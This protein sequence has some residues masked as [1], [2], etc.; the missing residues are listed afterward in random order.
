MAVAEDMGITHKKAS[1]IFLGTA[2][3]AIS[4]L[5][6]TTDA[7]GGAYPRTTAASSD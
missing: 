6:S 3:K 4:W 2:K 5:F 1:A 7:V